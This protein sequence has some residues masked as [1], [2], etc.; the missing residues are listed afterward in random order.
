[1]GKKM[2]MALR[3]FGM[4][5]VVV[6]AYAMMGMPEQKKPKAVKS[7]VQYIRCGVC[8]EMTRNIY[9]SVK[10][11]RDELRPGKKVSARVQAS[12]FDSLTKPRE[13]SLLTELWSSP[14]S[15]RRAKSSNW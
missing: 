15:W 2:K 4:A 3:W 10:A 9:R 1:M 7:D 11:M 12:W 13:R 6:G 8:E 5:M 14:R